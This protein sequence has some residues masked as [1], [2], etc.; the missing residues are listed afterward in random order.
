MLVA[1]RTRAGLLSEDLRFGDGS[2]GLGLE[3]VTCRPDVK[4]AI[5]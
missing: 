3:L 1:G 4:G 2:M 5:P